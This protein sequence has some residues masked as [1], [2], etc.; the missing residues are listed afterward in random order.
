MRILDHTGLQNEILTEKYMVSNLAD[1]EITQQLRVLVDLP[2]DP[3]WI[4]STYGVTH[5]Y[6]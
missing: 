6:W 3:G 2:E 4:S 5:N 1:E